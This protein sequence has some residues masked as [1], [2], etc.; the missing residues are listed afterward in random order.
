MNKIANLILAAF[1]FY[2]F[3]IGSANCQMNKWTIGLIYFFTGLIGII[4]IYIVDKNREKKEEIRQG[5]INK[6]RIDQL[7][8]EFCRSDYYIIK[9]K[10]GSN[11]L[12]LNKNGF[13]PPRMD[14]IDWSDVTKITAFKE[15]GDSRAEP[16]PYYA[17]SI[18]LANKELIRIKFKRAGEHVKV[19]EAISQWLWKRQTLKE[20]ETLAEIRKSEL[21]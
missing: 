7:K 9:I 12:I 6:V 5:E 11:E 14:F 19:V 17:L 1:C 21:S 16:T 4:S 13:I 2:L 15:G 3:V 8:E 20:H 18:C 10:I